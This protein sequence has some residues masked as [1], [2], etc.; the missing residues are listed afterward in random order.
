MGGDLDCGY[1]CDQFTGLVGVVVPWGAYCL[2]SWV[3]L[4]EPYSSSA[5]CVLL[6][7]VV[8][9]SVGVDLDSVMSSIG[10]FGY[11][12]LCGVPGESFKGFNRTLYPYTYTT[13]LT[14]RDT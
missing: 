2:I 4:T 14:T 13:V 5:F 9:G 6:T 1:C 8:A 3:V 7:V 11:A 12:S 10:S